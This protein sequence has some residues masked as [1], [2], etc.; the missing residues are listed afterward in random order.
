MAGCECYILVRVP[1][2]AM[3]LINMYGWETDLYPCL[4]RTDQ[5]YTSYF[6]VHVLNRNYSAHFK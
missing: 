3:R 6:V 4:I 1:C 5:I 2:L